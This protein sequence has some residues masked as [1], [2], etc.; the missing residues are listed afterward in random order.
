MNRIASGVR[1]ARRLIVEFGNL[2]DDQLDDYYFDIQSVVEDSQGN[3]L[4]AMTGLRKISKKF[5]IGLESVIDDFQ[6]EILNNN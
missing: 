5:R 4:K 6:S 1:L 2:S 3:V